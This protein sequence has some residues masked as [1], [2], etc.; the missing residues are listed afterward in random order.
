MQE[1]LHRQPEEDAGPQRHRQLGERQ[2]AAAV[3]QDKRFV[4][5]GQLQVRRGI[6]HRHARE[7]GEGGDHQRRTH[8]RG[9]E[10]AGGRGE[11]NGQLRA[12]RAQR[13]GSQPDGEGR[14]H[15]YRDRGLAAGSQAPEGGA[16]I[17]GS[18]HH[19]ELPQRQQVDEQQEIRRV[20]PTGR[21]GGAG[22]WNQQRHHQRHGQAEP[23]GPDK[24][25]TGRLADRLPFAQQL[26]GVVERLE[27]RRADAV[28]HARFE[29]PHHAD[30]E[31]WHD[32]HVR[33]MQEQ[34]QQGRHAW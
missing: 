31:Q 13:Q 10:G 12:L 19:R 29:L 26:R 17:H 34:E 3:L 30:Q 23:G 8:E 15:Q 4:D 9:D 22:P 11:D 21:Q 6:V 18:Q 32:R 24:D 28:L 25:P 5:H 2:V 16:R 27:K 7:L 33:E 20:G 1:G 14:L